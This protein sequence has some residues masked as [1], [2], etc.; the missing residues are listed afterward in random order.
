[1]ALRRSPV[2]IGVIVAIALGMSGAAGAATSSLPKGPIART[3][4]GALSAAIKRLASTRV[5]ATTTDRGVHPASLCWERDYTD[6]VADAPIDAVAFRL[7]YDCQ[8]ASWH[9]S[10]TLAAPLD[11]S[12]FDSL[13]S[14]VDTDND[15][16]NGCDGFD[17]L[18][19]G[20]FDGGAPKGVIAATPSC[21]SNTWTTVGAATFGSS[22][23]SLSLAYS[24]AALGDADQLV[25]NAGVVPKAATD[26]VDELPDQGVL[27][28][29]KFLQQTNAHDGYWLVD[30]AG[31]VHAYGNAKFRGDLAGR[32]LSQPIVGMARKSDRGGY[33]LLGRDG[34]V[35]TF[36]HVAYYGSTGALHL[37]RPVVSMTATLSG[38]G[39]WFVAADGGVF[40]FGDAAF[41]G[42]TG[43]IHLNRPIVGMAATPNGDGYWLV[44]ADG[45]IF[46]FGDA[47]FH[48]STGAINLVSPIVGMTPSP[49]GRGYRFVAADGGIFGFGDAAFF[50]GL[51]GGQP[52]SPVVGMG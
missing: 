45:G 39:Y 38:H 1:M 44:A 8:T 20:I 51:G 4:P 50:G 46:S 14:E 24:E 48:G 40:S 7:A 35:F 10:V 26:I 6:P 25:W 3:D 12:K 19:A 47:V 11:A 31:G 34:G 30:A 22:G 17:L 43:A 23:S 32:H 36:G 9:F 33:W 29:D 27:V 5:D 18:I 52:P 16:S 13:A 15:P 37:N 41:H 49:T 2:V 21:D 28:A 42:S